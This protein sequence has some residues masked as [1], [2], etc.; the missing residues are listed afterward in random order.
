MPS[1]GPTRRGTTKVAW[2]P[3][4][5]LPRRTRSS[6]QVS[7]VTRTP[8]SGFTIRIYLLDEGAEGPEDGEC[9]LEYTVPYGVAWSDEW[10]TDVNLFGGYHTVN[11]PESVFLKEGQRF[12]VVEWILSPTEDGGYYVYSP[13]EASSGTFG[14]SNEYMAALVEGQSY[15]YTTLEVN[16]EEV[17]GWFDLYWLQ[18]NGYLTSDLFDYVSNT[19]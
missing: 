10:N 19:S 5:S 14:G 13:I 12:S 8:L 17:T 9:V 7:V 15:V 6:C 3:T 18:Q 4:S 2:S 16:G 11:L 1:P